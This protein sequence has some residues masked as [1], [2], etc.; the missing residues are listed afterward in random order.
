MQDT[1]IGVSASY[2][3]EPD[4]AWSAAQQYKTYLRKGASLA[5]IPSFRST[6][7]GIDNL[8][9]CYP[10]A[11]VPIVAYTLLNAVDEH[12]S[13]RALGNEEVR[14]LVELMNDELKT[15]ITF[16]HEG[17]KLSLGNSFDRLFTGYASERNYFVTGDIPFARGYT[18]TK[19]DG[20]IVID[21]NARSLLRGLTH[22]TRNF[23]NV[24][25]VDDDVQ[26]FKEPN[27]YFFSERGLAGLM[28]MADFFYSNR[29]DGGLCQAVVEYINEEAHTNKRFRTNLC[30][31]AL[32]LGLEIGKTYLQK[33]YQLNRP[34]NLERVSDLLSILYQFDWRFSFQHHDIFRMLDIDGINNDWV[35]YEGLVRTLESRGKLDGRIGR[36]RTAIAANRDRFP[37]VSNFEDILKSYT[38]AIDEHLP[39]EHQVN[40]QNLEEFFERFRTEGSRELADL[41]LSSP[42]PEPAGTRAGRSPPR[43]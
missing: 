6:I 32:P 38:K 5:T 17:R 40:F 9:F 35:L 16:E 15:R 42:R 36:L 7:N 3:I 43:R 27:V 21:F 37:V 18:G 20:D 29:K 25:K 8:K 28:R 41:I 23:Y 4:A 11:G 31:V 12:A 39:A 22:I 1:L 30:K 14:N 24:G 19:Y 33:R 26:P 2:N 34:L 10:L 13:V